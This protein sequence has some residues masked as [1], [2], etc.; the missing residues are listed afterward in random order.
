MH[1]FKRTVSVLLVALLLCGV[2][3]AAPFSASAA[4]YSGDCGAAGSNVRWELDTT[5][6]TLTIT[7]TGVIKDF[8]ESDQQ[9]WV[10]GIDPNNS[11]KY[12]TDKVS[13]IENVIIKEGIT[14]IGNYAFDMRTTG[15]AHLIGNTVLKSVTLPSTLESIGDYAF[16]YCEMIERIDLP[17][18]LTEL[19]AG[20][21][22]SS[23]LKS[24]VIPDGITEIPESAFSHN[25]HMESVT[26]PSS[27]TKI[28]KEAFQD[29]RV[30]PE[31]KI[32]A[33]V[34]EIGQYAFFSCRALKELEFH[35]TEKL[36]IGKN[37]FAYAYELSEVN[38]HGETELKNSAFYQCAKLEKVVCYKNTTLENNNNNCNVFDLTPIRRG[39]GGQGAVYKLMGS[40]AKI[41]GGGLSVNIRELRFRDKIMQLNLR[42]NTEMNFFADLKQEEAQDPNVKMVFKIDNG[43]SEPITQIATE[44]TPDP[45]PED[46]YR[47]KFTCTDIA[48]AEMNVNVKAT[49]YKPEYV[50]GPDQVQDTFTYTVK[51]YADSVLAD[52]SV[53]GEKRTE[54]VN[55]IKSMLDYGANAQLAFNVNTD[56]L[57]NEGIDSGHDLSAVTAETIKAQFGPTADMQGNLLEAAGL[58]Y[59]GSSLIYLDKMTLRHYYLVKDRARFDSIKDTITF[60]GESVESRFKLDGKYVYFDKIDIPAAEMDNDFAIRIAD[61]DYNYSPMDYI[62]QILGYSGASEAD[63]KLAAATYYYNQA[64]NAYFD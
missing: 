13:K 51:E 10:D 39:Q 27:L 20:A 17:A 58:T 62:Q 43:Y 38:F 16:G 54:L 60:D 7:G 12:L 21:F 4:E 37:A 59:Y 56:N 42:G 52:E 11:E 49:L 47:Y 35:N 5:T 32:P 36:T 50:G 33:S 29:N 30:L 46:L 24:I 48:A 22:T 19:G 15:A 6:K 1:L 25:Q 26:L 40:D 3:A 2:F 23:G 44:A 28:G 41:T 53:G 18:G 61:V 63:K 64:A 9:P 34:T 55:L 31:I 45:T 57:V 8:T 14:R